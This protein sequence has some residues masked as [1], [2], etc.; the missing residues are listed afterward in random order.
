VDSEFFHLFISTGPGGGS[1]GTSLSWGNKV[2]NEEMTRQRR[3][4]VM[5]VRLAW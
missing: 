3:E 5:K 1:C 4:G 2:M